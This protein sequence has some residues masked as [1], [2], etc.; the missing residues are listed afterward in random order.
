MKVYV[1]LRY[2]ICDAVF[3]TEAAAN[4]WLDIHDDSRCGSVVR[5]YEV[6]AAMPVVNANRH[7]YCV[8]LYDDGDGV[9][10]P[11]IWID[12]D[13]ALAAAGAVEKSKKKHGLPRWYLTHVWAA[14]AAEAVKSAKEKLGLL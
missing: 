14:T 1:V 3:S 5:E 4:K 8:T 12:R 11:V 10:W 6:D 7:P 13:G 9:L 2:D